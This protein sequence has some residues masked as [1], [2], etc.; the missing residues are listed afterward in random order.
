M[1]LT[2]EFHVTTKNN[3]LHMKKLLILTVFASISIISMAQNQADTTSTVKLNEVVINS[4]KETSP[5][6]T[7]VSSTLLNSKLINNAQITNIRDMSGLVPNFFIPDYGSALSTTAY[8]RGYGSRNS[9]QSIALYVDNVPYFD[10]STFDFDFF[11]IKQIEVLRGAQGTL[12]GRNAM[13]GIVNIYTLSPFNFQGTKLSLSTGNYG[14]LNAKLSHYAKLSDNFGVSVGSFYNHDDGFLTNQYT[15][16][17]QDAT[18]SAGGRLKLDWNIT[19]NFK[20]QYT[21]NFDYVNQSAFPYGAYDATTGKTALPNFNDPSTYTRS[22]LTNSLFLQ[23]KTKDVV[24]SSTTSHQYFSDDM[25]LDNDFTPLSYFSLEQQQK[26]N[27]FNEEIILRSNAKQDYQWSFGLNGF[28][29]ELDI[30]APFYFKK[31]GLKYILQPSFGITMLIT[32]TIMKTPGLFNTNTMGGA[33]FHQS[34]YNN[35]LF[36]GLSLT[37]GLRVDYEKVKLNY[38]TGTSLDLNMIMGPQTIPIQIADTLKGNIAVQFSEL[39]PKIALKYEWTDRQFVYANVS[40]GYKAGGF[41]VQMSADLVSKGLEPGGSAATTPETVMKTISYKPEYSWNYEIGGQCLSFNDHLKSSI[42]LFYININDLQLTQFVPNGL[43]RKIANAGQAVSKGL[44]FAMEANLGSGFSAALNYGY[45]N[46]TFST[47]TDSV[48]TYDPVTHQP[49]NTKV[50]YKG[51]FVPYAPQNTL[52][53]SAN[54]EHT[55]KN[56]CIDRLFASV[57]YTGIGKIYWTEA[58]DISQDFYSLL[59]AKVGVNKGA[60]GLEVWAKNLLDTHYNA[61][62]FDSSGSKFFQVG[63]PVEFGATLKVEF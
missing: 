40:R 43:G 13:G 52:S 41:N 24:L 3:Y 25:K 59:N 27:A 46:A 34:T 5:Q 57:Q 29:Q 16:K 53:L 48:Q 35:F 32:D 30:D 47:Y 50:D 11:D 22:T 14:F 18:T 42:S 8:V 6:Q 39:L 56:A 44:E 1:N 17:S 2:C 23:Y 4:L 51:K 61:F 55:F 45:A 21:G 49:I 10:K 12:Y 28:S 38:N 58:N 26:Q 31:D 62:Y 63:R 9:G 33:I 20:A 15:H 37:A 54:Y 60:L 7:P 36:K 19:P